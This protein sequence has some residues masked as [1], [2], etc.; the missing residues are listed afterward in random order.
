MTGVAGAIGWAPGSRAHDTALGGQRE[1]NVVV[2]VCFCA[3]FFN[4]VP[5]VPGMRYAWDDHYLYIAYETFD[6][7]LTAQG[8]GEMQGPKDNR[9]EGAALSIATIAA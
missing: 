3:R 7:N 5:D 2:G 1:L 4:E 9:R 6:A 8:T